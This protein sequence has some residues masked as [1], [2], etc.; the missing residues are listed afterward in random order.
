AYDLIFLGTPVWAWTFTPP[1]RSFLSKFD[2]S[3]KKI[4]IWTCSAGN[5]HKAMERF[6]KALN[7]LD[8]LGDIR[9]QVP[10]QSNPEEVKKE[11]INWA[12]QIVEK[13]NT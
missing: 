2:L 3:G 4:A 7:G 5:G 11:A 6:K 10:L 9:F 12:K 8:I 13:V 1:I